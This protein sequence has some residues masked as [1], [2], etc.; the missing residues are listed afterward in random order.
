MQRLVVEVC[1]YVVF[2][3]SVV[4]RTDSEERGEREAFARK[5]L[6]LGDDL[7][8]QEGGKGG[9]GPAMH[10]LCSV[11]IPAITPP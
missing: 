8:L 4:R 6:S 2:H 11:R 5:M 7:K 3:Y 10:I 1:K 9:T